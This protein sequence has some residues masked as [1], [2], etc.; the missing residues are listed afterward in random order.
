[1]REGEGETERDLECG[2]R[3]EGDRDVEERLCKERQRERQ[4]DRD[5]GSGRKDRKRQET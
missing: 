3:T 1:M 5:V 2:K 4:R